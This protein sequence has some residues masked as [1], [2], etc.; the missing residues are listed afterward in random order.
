MQKKKKNLNDSDNHDG[1]IPHLEQCILEWKIKWALGSITKIKASRSDGIPIE[2]FEILK[3]DAVKGLHKFGKLSSGHRSGKSQ[4][5]FQSQRK[6]MPTDV[7]GTTQFHSFHML[8][9]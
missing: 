9:R 6:A 4:F 5:S 2:L 7:Q 8:A 1:V 3:D